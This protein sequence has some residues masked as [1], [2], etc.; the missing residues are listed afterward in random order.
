M[1]LKYP[2]WKGS[3]EIYYQGIRGYGFYPGKIRGEGLFVSV[4]RKNGNSVEVKSGVKKKYNTGL[5]KT[6][7]EIVKEWTNFPAENTIRTGDDIYVIPCMMDDYRI[8][9]QK[10][11]IIRPGT[12]ICTVKNDYIP[13]HDLAIST[14]IKSK[15]F[16]TSRSGLQP[17][18]S[19]S[20]A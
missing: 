4:M 5:R 19:I 12:R 3:T 1:N 13:A 11:K 6:D 7:I 17:G 15:A 18:F 2:N 8:L 14:S 10:L 9:E 20:A 16:P